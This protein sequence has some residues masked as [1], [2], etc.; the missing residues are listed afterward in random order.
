[1]PSWPTSR[2]PSSTITGLTIVTDDGRRS[3]ADG[4][5]TSSD[6]PPIRM[7][8]DSTLTY[9]GATELEING[10]ALAER[11]HWVDAREGRLRRLLVAQFE[12][13]LPTNDERYQYRLP[14]P[15]T[16]GGL[17]L[18]RWTF[19]YRLADAGAPETADTLALLATHHLVLEEEQLMA[20]YATILG[21]EARHELL[22]FFHE[23]V[24][25][26][27]HALSALVDEEGALR[28]EHAAVATEL[29]ARARR[30]FRLLPEG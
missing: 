28:P 23:P 14:D 18:G 25:R 6:A 9:L 8:V 29:H 21:I 11:H 15:V 10:I 3:W 30:A 24:R 7:A 4:I 26:L 5:L 1:M 20:R 12:H 19:G 27:G 22:V 13:F 17:T 16:L 2:S